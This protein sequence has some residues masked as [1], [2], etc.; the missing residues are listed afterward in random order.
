[1]T[2]VITLPTAGR[3]DNPSP[4]LW[5]T[6]V[7]NVIQA[8]IEA[9]RRLGHIGVVSGP[10]GIGKSTAARAA[11]RLASEAGHEASYVTLS[12]ASGEIRS[13]LRRICEKAFGSRTD[14]S[15]LVDEMFEMVAGSFYAPGAVLVIDE[16]QFAS[17]ELLDTLRTIWDDLSLRGASTAL[18]FVGTPELAAT[19]NPFG[20]KH[21]QLE[22]LCGR[23]GTRAVLDGLP[24]DDFGT[25]T[26]HLGIA[27]K[28]AAR[29]IK[30][31]ARHQG[32]HAVD[33]LVRQARIIAGQGAPI[34]MHH[35][36]VAFD[37]RGVS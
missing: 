4:G 32:L 23:I 15:I 5:P 20:G 8:A 14:R 29:L 37:A 10:S 25:I 31:V 24:D 28:D 36:K 35:L 13:G 11:V 33:R 18:V 27:G 16:A 19:L 7:A 9:C 22:P 30:E 3:V 21:R 1:M 17:V 2:E 26:R 12:R 6:Q 34:D